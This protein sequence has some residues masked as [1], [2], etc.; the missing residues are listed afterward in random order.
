MLDP[1]HAAGAD[2]EI[3]PTLTSDGEGRAFSRV[4]TPAAV[5][6][7]AQAIVIHDPVTKAKIACADLD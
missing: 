6:L 5:S 1:T 3:W 4:V 2:N 7:G